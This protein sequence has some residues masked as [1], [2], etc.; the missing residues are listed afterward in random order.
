MPIYE[1]SCSSC[2]QVCDVLQKAQDPAPS[3]C[4][5]CGAKGTLTRIVSRTS[6]IL[7]GGGWYSDLYGTPKKESADDKPKPDAKSDASTPATAAPKEAASKPESPKDT[8]KT[9][10]PA[11][12]TPKPEK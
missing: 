5:K 11:P 8:P 1:Y 2:G 7:K 6:F 10:A 9:P 4:E 3:E 12:A